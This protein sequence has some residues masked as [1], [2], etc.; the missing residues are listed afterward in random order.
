MELQKK[1]KIQIRIK[2]YIG[3]LDSLCI[4]HSEVEVA[5]SFIHSLVLLHSEVEVCIN[6]M[7]KGLVSPLQRSLVW[8]LLL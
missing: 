2:W 6:H 8:N 1:I 5:H 7:H 3:E 4:L